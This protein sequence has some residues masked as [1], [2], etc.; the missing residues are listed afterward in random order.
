MNYR[1]VIQQEADFELNETAIWYETQ[2]EKLGLR[3]I[4]TTL[5]HLEHVRLNPKHYEKKHKEYR[6]AL[7]PD[8]P[9]VIV[10]RIEKEKHSV[11]VV[12]IFHTSRNPKHKYNR[13]K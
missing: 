10:Y 4:D 12:A 3:F 6:E 8:F 11:I 2:Q 5:K 9:F 13:E 7:V 1:L